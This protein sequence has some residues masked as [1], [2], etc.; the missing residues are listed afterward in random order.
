MC[1]EQDLKVSAAKQMRL[2]KHQ[3]RLSQK[4]ES[5]KEKKVPLSNICMSHV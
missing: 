1:I 5:E 3:R 2:L 4:K